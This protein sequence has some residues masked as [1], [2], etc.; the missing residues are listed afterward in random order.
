MPQIQHFPSQ[1]LPLHLKWQLLSY[2]RVEWWWVF[3][4]ANRF[5]D[6]TQKATHPVNFM[7][8]EGDYLIS[9]AEV[10][11][12]DMEHLSTPYRVYGVSAVFT[13]PTHRKE[14]YGQQVVEAATQ[15][16]L[17]SDADVAMLFCLPE[18]VKFYQR[19]GWTHVPTTLLFGDKES[20]DEDKLESLM[21]LFVSYKGKAAQSNFENNSV[22][23]GK[24]TW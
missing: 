14:G 7:L 20:P 1:E 18:L 16:I 22:Y 24:Y 5:W 11:W 2:V 12:R 10:N 21:M 23:V 9:H 6:Y 3:Q 19:C 4:G 8:T 15:Y 17:S 13:Y